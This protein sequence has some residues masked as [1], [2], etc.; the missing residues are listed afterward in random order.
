M[1]GSHGGRRKGAGRPVTTGAGLTPTVS[2]KLGVD[3]YETAK[4]RAP[5][6]NVNG[7]AKRLMLRWLG[8]RKGKQA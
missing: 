1:A 6:G 5:R 7:K 4:E 3:D 8:T 2:F